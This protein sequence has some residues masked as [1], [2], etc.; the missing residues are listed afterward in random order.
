[1][2]ENKNSRIVKIAQISW[3]QKNWYAVFI[4]ADKDIQT[5]YNNFHTRQQH[6][7]SVCNI[8]HTVWLSVWNQNSPIH[9]CIIKYRTFWLV[10]SKTWCR[11]VTQNIEKKMSPQG[12]NRVFH[13]RKDHSVQCNYT[14]IQSL[15]TPSAAPPSTLSMTDNLLV[16]Y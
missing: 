14:R 1:M 7:D 16:A 8:C 6:T 13:H 15:T 12:V 3:A 11:Y 4:L 5:V 9:L 10:W 2:H